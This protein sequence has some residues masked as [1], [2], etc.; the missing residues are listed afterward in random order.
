[1]EMKICT[2]KVCDVFLKGGVVFDLVIGISV[3]VCVGGGEGMLLKGVLAI[4][5][6]SI[7][8]FITSLWQSLL[9]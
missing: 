8:K 5:L 9:R 6:R 4:L 1:M 3:Y 2:H 7:R